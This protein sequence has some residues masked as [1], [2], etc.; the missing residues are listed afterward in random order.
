MFVLRY[1]FN[2][3]TFFLKGTIW[4]TA[5]ERASVFSCEDDAKAALNKRHRVV[6]LMGHP[7]KRITHEATT[8]VLEKV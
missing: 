4:T 6:G 5:K 3:N 7:K 2:R 8:Y 1:H